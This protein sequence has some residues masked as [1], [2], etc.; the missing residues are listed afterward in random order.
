M[1]SFYYQINKQKQR[2]KLIVSEISLMFGLNYK[3]IIVHT[4]V[5]M[6]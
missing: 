2:S 3:M 4:F 5:L 6:F 1:N